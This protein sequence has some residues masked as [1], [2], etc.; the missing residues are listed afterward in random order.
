MR[1]QA[2]RTQVSIALLALVVPFIGQSLFA[3]V[4]VKTPGTQFSVISGKATVTN[5]A[6]GRRFRGE[7]RADLKIRAT[8]PLPARANPS[9]LHKMGRLA[10]HFHASP[11]G[12]SVRSVQLCNGANCNYKFDTNLRGDYS[13]R[14]TIYT[15]GAQ[16]ANVWVLNPPDMV[17]SQFAVVLE[18]LFPGGI[19]SR[20]DPG[21]F[22]LTSVDADFPDAVA[23][24]MG[25]A[26]VAVAHGTD[27]V[28]IGNK[29]AVAHG[30]DS[31]R[32]GNMVLEYNSVDGSAVMKGSDGAVL[33]TYSAGGFA[34][35]W[36][37]IV[38]TQHGTL[39][40]NSRTGVGSVVRFDDSGNGNTIKTYPS[41]GAPSFARGWTSIT[42][43]AD[44]LLFKNAATGA[45]ALGEIDSSGDFRT[46]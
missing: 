32:I 16:Y 44:G 14:E 10:I 42:L 39:F 20:I 6:D 26:K 41:P 15:K 11:G 12:P 43:T 28:R 17:G 29:V 34:P 37:Q 4:T 7:E 9:Q 2:A 5:V 21:E 13:T 46:K 31:V 38:W 22:V 40:Y 27:S 23:V 35:G 3:Q 1:Y 24:H 30:T 18:V 25:N 45:R 36:T 33:R 8:L 19:D